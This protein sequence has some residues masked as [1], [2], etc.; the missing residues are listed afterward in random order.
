[1][2]IPHGFDWIILGLAVLQAVALVPVISRLRGRDSAVR[3]KAR[4]DLLDAVGSLLLLGGLLLSSVVAWSWFWLVFAGLA[5]MAAVYAVKG[6]HWL[7]A[8]RPTA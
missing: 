8:R 5:V 1:M 6:V 3:F 2:D 4:L 7:R